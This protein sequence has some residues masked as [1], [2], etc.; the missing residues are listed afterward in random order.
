MA[1][2]L[3]GKALIFP[4]DARRRIFM[5]DAVVILDLPPPL[6]EIGE[7]GRPDR[8][9]AVTARQVEHIGRLAESGHR[10]AEGAGYPLARS[11]RGAEMRGAAREIAVMEVVGLDPHGDEAAQQRGQDG[12]VV[13]D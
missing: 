4:F 3:R 8:H 11:D 9:L 7:G 5:T 13:V 6:S 1:V 10:E 12:R 2:T